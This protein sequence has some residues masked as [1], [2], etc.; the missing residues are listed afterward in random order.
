MTIEGAHFRSEFKRWY[1]IWE[2]KLNN[3]NEEMQGASNTS[4]KSMVNQ[5]MV[6]QA[7]L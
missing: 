6:N 1:N 2:R 4:K 7:S 5:S 3:R